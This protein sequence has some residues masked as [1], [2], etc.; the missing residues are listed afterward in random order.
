V[1]VGN[2]FVF[3]HVPK[4]GGSFIEKILLSERQGLGAR[5]HVH[6]HLGARDLKPAERDGKLVFGFVRHPCDWY[7]STFAF[8]QTFFRPLAAYHFGPLYEAWAPHLRG[9]RE[10]QVA[11]FRAA[12]RARVGDWSHVNDYMLLDEKGAP[13]CGVGKFE[14]LRADL[15]GFLV[16]AGCDVNG[17][18]EMIATK[19]PVHVSA[20][21]RDWRLY[22][23]DALLEAVA[24]ADRAMIQRFGYADL[25][26][27]P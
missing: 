25:L 22:Y 16:Q 21:D 13:A 7:V 5:R 17:L 4:T 10:T 11:R 14:T 27:A 3:T 24:N 6:P 8:L 18:A 19:S 20:R 2:R 1:I 26:V 23:D 12:L 15:R 9:S